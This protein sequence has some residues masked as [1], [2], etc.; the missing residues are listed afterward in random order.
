[1]YILDTNILR[2]YL[3][4][5]QNYPYMATQI[6]RGDLQHLLCITIVTA[7]ELVAWR[8]HPL[9]DRPD[10]KER[11]L[12]DLYEKFFKVI[13]II[14]RFQVLPLDAAAYDR[15]LSLAHLQTTI[16]TRDRRIA[17]IALANNATVVTGNTQD[18]E[19]VP[20]LAV[21]DWTRG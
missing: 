11:V 1:V 16:G 15:F 7:Q 14:K 2:Y 10:Q 21:E 9:K 17:A 8:L 3:T 12:L 13:A 6:D 5:P 18:F 19:L 4:Q 20:G